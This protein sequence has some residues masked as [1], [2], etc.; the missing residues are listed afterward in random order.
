MIILNQYPVFNRSEFQLSQKSVTLNLV[1]SFYAVP[2]P[3]LLSAIYAP[4]GE[5]ISVVFNVE[6]NLGGLVVNRPFLCS[7]LFVF[8]SSDA[9]ICRWMNSTTIYIY[10]ASQSQ[11]SYAGLEDYNQVK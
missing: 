9:C 6:T 1:S 10:S 3:R 2:V 11:F 4:S 5:F 8:S 7:S